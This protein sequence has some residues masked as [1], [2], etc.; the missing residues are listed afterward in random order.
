MVKIEYVL[1][2]MDGLM[3]DS[4]KI[5]TDVTNAILAP[6]GCEMTWDIKAGCMGKPERAAAEHLL[7]HFPGISLTLESYLTQR[8]TLQD[9]MWPTVPLLPGVAKLV[10]HLKKHGIPIA[11]ATGSRRRNYE[12]KTGHLQGVFGCF[13]GRVVCADDERWV[14]K[15]KPEPDIFLVAARDLLRRDVGEVRSEIS[16]AH[17]AERSKGLVFEDGLPGMQAGKRAGMNVIWIPDANLLD[18]EY[19]GEEKADA[20]LRSM[21]EFVPEEWGL[22]PY[23]AEA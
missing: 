16:E 9:A 23:D 8:N 10:L 20:M 17:K 3:I 12:L 6:Y 21:Q 19:V 13:D 5:Y 2:D 22:P 7:S 15:G 11:V 14:M 1:F 18:V 4:E